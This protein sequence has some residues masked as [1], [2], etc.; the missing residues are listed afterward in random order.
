MKH[1]L[2]KYSCERFFSPE[3]VSACSNDVIFTLEKVL[4]IRP[5]SHEAVELYL[6]VMKPIFSATY[7]LRY[8]SFT[9]K[10]LWVHQFPACLNL[11]TI[12]I[13]GQIIL[14]HRGLLS[15]VPG[16]YLLDPR[17]TPSLSCDFQ[18]SPDI[19]KCALG[20]KITPG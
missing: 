10:T 8:S 13:S 17:S 3:I 4:T 16:L 15:S 6:L 1:V 12:H 5:S 2:L 20:G 19:G 11:S 18:L 14:C 7:T 9:G